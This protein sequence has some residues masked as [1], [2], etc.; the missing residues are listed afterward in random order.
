MPTALP[1]IHNAR[2][3]EH[4]I[5]GPVHSRDDQLQRMDRRAAFRVA[6]R[7]RREKRGELAGL[8]RRRTPASSATPF[9]WQRP[10]TTS[11]VAYGQNGEP[12]RVEQGYPIRM[13][14]PGWEGPF[15]VKYLRHI[16]VVDEPYHTWNESMNHSVPRADLGGKSRWYH[17]EWGPKSVITRPS[18]GLA[19]PARAMSRLPAWRGPAAAWSRR[20]MYRPTAARPG[21]KRRSRRRCIRRPIPGSLSTGLGTGKR[22]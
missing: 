14:V 8:R 1:M 4:G 20:S 3:C 2:Q 5:A 12:V 22:R 18:A 7:G 10:W 15:N 9:R 17:F 19:I 16:K 11:I 6:E 13:I 21:R